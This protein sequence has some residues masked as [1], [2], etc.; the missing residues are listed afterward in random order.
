MGIGH[1]R[2]PNCRYLCSNFLLFLR[3]TVWLTMAGF[4]G[5]ASYPNEYSI[6]GI[7]ISH[8]QGEINWTKLQSATIGDNPI[9]FIIIKATEGAD[10]LDENFNDNFYNARENGFIRGAYH[11]FKPNTP[12]LLQAKYFL[13]QVHLEPGDLPPVLDIEE[14][15][16]LTA[17]Q[18]KKAALTWL[19]TVEKN[20]VSNPLYIQITNLSYNISQTKI[21][22][23]TRIGLR[24]TT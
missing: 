7:D 22:M 8:H 4:Y 16:N 9:R 20:M 15:G 13:K 12:A 19:H 6:Q 17:A 1:R 23:T 24:T 10:F 21:S 3:R 5:D 14:K 18:L 11:Y 2:N